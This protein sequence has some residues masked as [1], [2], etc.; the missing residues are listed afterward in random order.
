MR[1]LYVTNVPSPYRVDYFNEL[2]K[3]CDLTVVFEKKTSDERDKSWQNYKFI[4]FKGVFLEGK[5][6]N[7]DT[8]FCPG[9]INYV[10]DKSFDRIIITNISSPTGIMAIS[11]MKIL[12]I[13]YWIEGDGGFVNAGNGIKNR[14]KRFLIKDAEGLFS[15]SCSHDN[16][17][18]TYGAIDEKIHRYPFT[19]IKKEDIINAD[20][21]T[22]KDKEELR[23]KLKIQ[24]HRIILT[25]GRFNYGEENSKGID[26]VM[27]IA[28]RLRDGYSFYIIGD[29]PA[30]KF[31]RWKEEK[32]LTNVHFVGYLKNEDLAEYYAVSDCFVLFSRG[33]AWGLAINEAMMYGLP[34]ITTDNCVKGLSLVKNDINGFIVVIDNI[35]D[36]VEKLKYVTEP[37]N[38]IRLGHASYEMFQHFIIEERAKADMDAL[39]LSK[40]WVGIKRDLIRK[41]ARKHL[42]IPDQKKVILYV[43]QMIVRKGIDIFLNAILKYCRDSNLLFIFVGGEVPEFAISI[44]Q[45][46]PEDNIRVIPFLE[47]EELQYCYR[48]SDMF[49][50]PTREDIW[51]L[52]INEAMAFGLPV[53]TTDRCIA[54]LELVKNDF[55]GYIVSA[56]EI[57]PLAEAIKMLLEGNKIEKFGR[58][59]R[60]IIEDF[61]IEKM[62]ESHLNILERNSLNARL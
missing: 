3:S 61:T 58:R 24:E 5:S 14:I 13:P 60:K 10:R 12:K 25:V 6:I 11:L 40:N 45:Q 32:E 8:A 38:S 50:L 23:S 7:T 34:I 19:S 47:H 27:T 56:G 49:V 15:T 17:Y 20:L 44:F 22:N 4:N 37:A 53:V 36:I 2:G 52:V 59:S 41:M 28:E 18:R 46:I 9:I 62:A 30:E 29:E 43:G 54:G 16:Y 26:I 51:G 39:A 35:D 33:D 48:A 57:L 21:L 55:N 1:V 31:V 42:A